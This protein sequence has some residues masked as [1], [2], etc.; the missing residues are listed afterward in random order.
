MTIP[1]LLAVACI[2]MSLV[3]AILRA[4]DHYRWG[5]AAKCA[6]STLFCLTAVAAIGQRDLPTNGATTRILI[7]LVLGLVGDVFLGLAPLGSKKMNLVCSGLGGAAFFTGHIF[8]IRALL[9]GVA[10]RWPLLLLLP[11]VPLVFLILYK[12]KIFNPG[13]RMIAIFGYG[14]V[15]GLM[16]VAAINYALHI[17]GGPLGDLPIGLLMW[18]PGILFA[19]SD[20]S[21]FLRTFGTEKIERFPVPLDFAVMLPYFSAQAIFALLAAYI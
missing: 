16:M 14:V 20:T 6:A 5:F 15:L 13:K 8:Y 17:A 11:V 10:L 19:I 12:T 9:M 7:G 2:L 1:Y 3:V 4:Y 21:L 18:V